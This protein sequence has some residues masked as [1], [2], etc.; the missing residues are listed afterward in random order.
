MSAISPTKNTGLIVDEFIRYATDHLRTVSGVASTVSLYPPAGTP[1]PGFVNWSGY[2]VPPSTPSVE[3][4]SPNLS[5]EAAAVKR[6]IEVEY[7]ITKRIFEDEIDEENWDTHNKDVDYQVALL[8]ATAWNADN[9]E[10]PSGGSGGS[11]GGGGGGGRGS[12]T[13]LDYRMYNGPGEELW[14]AIGSLEEGFVE[15]YR[16]VNKKT[17]K[18]TQ[19][20][21]EQNP[22]YIKKCI[23][24]VTVPL[25]GTMNALGGKKNPLSEQSIQVHKDLAAIVIPVIE[26]I[27]QKRMQKYLENCGGGL[28]VRTVTNGTRLSNHAWGTAIDFNSIRYPWGTNWN[29][30]TIITPIGNGNTSTRQMNDFDKGFLEVVQMF[31][32][33]GMLWLAR[34]DPMHISIYET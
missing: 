7:P 8:K 18:V 17:G 34:T 3:T 25:N 26:K 1:N 15:S 31:R 28:A 14:P 16:V 4:S 22:E 29:G 23:T 6:D 32:D 33:A 20:W 11:R 10:R 13:S 12:G 9:E 24:R 30:D 21:Y 27:K 19:I 2:F 5:D